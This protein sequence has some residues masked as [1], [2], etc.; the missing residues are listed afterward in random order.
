LLAALP[1]VAGT[2]LFGWAVLSEGRGKIW[3]YY[4]LVVWRKL[5]VQERFGIK[6]RD[7]YIFSWIISGIS[8]MNLQIWLAI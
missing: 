1:L 7:L 4:I 8:G 6:S 2:G 5:D 3:G